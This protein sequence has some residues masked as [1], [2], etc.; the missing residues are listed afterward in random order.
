MDAAQH[1]SLE[2]LLDVSKLLI[3]LVGKKLGNPQLII[4]IKKCL[5]ISR[6]LEI[7]CFVLTGKVQYI[8]VKTVSFFLN[9]VC[10]A[11]LV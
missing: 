11:E 9:V 3:L 7:L 1:L 5:V 2:L 10:F 4:I 8:Y 6:D